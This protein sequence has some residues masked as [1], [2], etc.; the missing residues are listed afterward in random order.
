MGSNFTSTELRNRVYE[1]IIEIVSQRLVYRPCTEVAG[2]HRNLPRSTDKLMV[3]FLSLTQSCQQIRAELRTWW[4]K[5]MTI[6]MQGLQAYLR[7][8]IEVP[9][10]PISI[11]AQTF[12]ATVGVIRIKAAAC[13]EVDL[14]LLLKIKTLQPSLPIHVDFDS[15]Y[16]QCHDSFVAMFDNQHSTWL[17]W[18]RNGIIRQARI[19]TRSSSSARPHYPIT[20]NLVLHRKHAVPWLGPVKSSCSVSETRLLDKTGLG[21]P[22]L[23]VVCGVVD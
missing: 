2:S 12:Q 21:I 15:D 22:G 16:A 13:T 5:S 23:S 19:T 1:E 18:I 6:C 9:R 17:R 4:L 14:V 11:A 10:V 7:A 20:L 3:P 8:F